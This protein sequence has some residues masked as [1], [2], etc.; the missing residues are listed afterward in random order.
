MIY[1]ALFIVIITSLRPNLTKL[2]Y[3]PIKLLYK[4]IDKNEKFVINK[5]IASLKLLGANKNTNFKL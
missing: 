1:F 4:F 5:L 3:K 2:P